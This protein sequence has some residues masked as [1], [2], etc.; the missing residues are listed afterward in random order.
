MKNREKTHLLPGII[1]SF[2]IAV[3]IVGVFMFHVSCECEAGKKYK[4]VILPFRDNTYMDLGEMVSDV[5]R[6]MVAQTEYFEI[7]DRDRLYETVIT[8]LPGNLI[9]VDNITRTGGGFTA[10][11]IDVIS[12][13][14]RK[15]IQRFSKKLR[16][17]YVIKGSISKFANALR[18][19]AEIIDVKGNEILGFVDVEGEPEKVL[20]DML[21]ALTGKILLFCRNLNSYDDALYTL[22]QYSQCLFTFD[23]AEK[24]LKELL[25]DLRDTIGIR[26]V[27]MTLYLTENSRTNSLS[28]KLYNSPEIDEKIIEEGEQILTLLENSFDEKVLEVFLSTGLDP[29]EE[30][31]NVYVNGG[32]MEKAIDIYRKAINVYPINLAEH[33]TKMGRLYCERGVDN[34]AILAFEKALEIKKSNNG[35]RLELVGLLKKNRF[36]ER[37]RKHL[38]VCM[39]YARNGE[40]IERISEEMDNLPVSAYQ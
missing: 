29:F 38:D 27:L 22:G 25:P 20:T 13:L 39:K 33:Y 23:V 1:R 11:Q 32:D 10:N 2:S 17:D 26:A 7:V 9:N 8:V 6:G 37:A 40:E 28:V 18:V 4:T 35:L 19:D 36:P 31:A 12:R 16:A 21:G 14:D 34:E 30:V 5:L 24:K 3:I 15:K